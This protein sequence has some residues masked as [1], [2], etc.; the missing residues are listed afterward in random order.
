MKTEYQLSH[1]AY[2]RYK[3]RVNKK[4]NKKD[5]LNWCVQAIAVSTFLGEHN[6]Y[7]YY[8]HKDYKL[9]VGEK[10]TIITISYFNDAYKETFRKEINAM[11]KSKF[12]NKLKP[13][14][15]VKK[16]QQINLYEAKIRYLN[17][18]NPKVKESIQTLI[19]EMEYELTRTIGS[20]DNIKSLS[21][22]Y[23]MPLDQ[24]IKE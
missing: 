13:L 15:K 9:V 7:R 2:E 10:N 24:L 23:N 20:I 4:G 22:H 6:C 16:K 21:E 11:I 14:Y 8:K 1:H 5:A 18:K 12:N 19:D 3:Q 17:A